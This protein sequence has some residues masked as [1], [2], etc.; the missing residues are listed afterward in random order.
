MLDSHV[1]T[2]GDPSR[3]GVCFE[4]LTKQFSFPLSSS[5]GV[6]HELFGVPVPSDSRSIM[7]WQLDDSNPSS[8]SAMFCQDNHVELKAFV[9]N[10]PIR[11]D[12]RAK[13]E[14]NKTIKIFVLYPYNTVLLLP[15]G[16]TL[17][18][19]GNLSS[20][21]YKTNGNSDHV[22]LFTSLRLDHFPIDIKIDLVITEWCLRSWY[23]D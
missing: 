22:S 17:G 18:K 8:A 15:Y 10:Q 7:V 9:L 16:L 5:S 13:I 23:I 1:L 4:L 19:F 6:L 11:D 21:Q 12:F 2:A 3:L 14:K 20:W